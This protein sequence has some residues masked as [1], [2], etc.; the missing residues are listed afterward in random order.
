L[1][2]QEKEDTEKLVDQDDAEDVVETMESPN[3]E[4]ARESTENGRVLSSAE[5]KKLLENIP[6]ERMKVIEG[7]MKYLGVSNDKNPAMVKGFFEHC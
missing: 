7:A 2:A 6:P 5:A 4:K 1:E 3:P